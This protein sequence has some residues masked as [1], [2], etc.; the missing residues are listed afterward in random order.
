MSTLTDM[1]LQPESQTFFRWNFC[2]VTLAW[3]G[4]HEGKRDAGDRATAWLD[5]SIDPICKL[6]TLRTQI[7]LHYLKHL[8]A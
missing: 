2:Q 3:Y 4:T 6:G 8:T 5:M 1:T 7:Y